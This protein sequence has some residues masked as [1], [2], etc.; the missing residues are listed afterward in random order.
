MA[1]SV[2]LSILATRF[3]QAQ[4]RCWIQVVST[5]P[6]TP[7]STKPSSATTILSLS[8]SVAFSAARLAM[9]RSAVRSVA[10]SGR[11]DLRGGLAMA[12]VNLR[13]G[14]R[15]Y[16]QAACNPDFIHP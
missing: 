3:C 7:V 2:S 1:F 11:G 5:V 13:E 12:D 9:R 14:A 4:P 15:Q 10:A 16:A 8:D 6:I